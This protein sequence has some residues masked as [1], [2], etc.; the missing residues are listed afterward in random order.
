MAYQDTIS[1]AEVLNEEITKTRS[2]L[3]RVAAFFA[4][5][6][7]SVANAGMARARYET[8]RTLQGMSDGQL[9]ELNIKREDTVKHVF[10]DHYYS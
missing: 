10:N 1:P 8:M 6:G 3:D 9:S 4:S 2:I 7:E 5:I